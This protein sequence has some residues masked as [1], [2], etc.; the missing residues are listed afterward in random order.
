MNAPLA[1]PRSQPREYYLFSTMQL[2]LEMDRSSTLV[3]AKNTIKVAQAECSRSQQ[4]S[5]SAS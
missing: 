5:W 2:I 1:M 3:L 4:T